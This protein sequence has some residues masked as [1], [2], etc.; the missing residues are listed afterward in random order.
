MKKLL[1]FL[2]V[3][4]GGY[5]YYANHMQ[6]G[7]APVDSYQ[8]LLKKVEASPVTRAEVMLGANDLATTFCNDVEF[9]RTGG[10]SVSECQ[11]KF[12]NFKEMCESRV[13]GDAPETYSQKDEVTATAKTYVSCVGIR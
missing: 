13:F 2:A 5:Y 8:A 3:A 4:G 11:S 12:S 1:L 7:I 10:S 9:Q 6:G